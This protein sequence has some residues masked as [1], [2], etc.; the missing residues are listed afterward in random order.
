M[1]KRGIKE[2]SWEAKVSLYKLMKTYDTV[3]K[4]DSKQAKH[5]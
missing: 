4:K 5:I 3:R 1:W 2:E